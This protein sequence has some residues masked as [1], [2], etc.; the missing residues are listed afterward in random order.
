MSESCGVGGVGGRL[1]G[2]KIGKVICTPCGVCSGVAGAV[3]T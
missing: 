3:G 1:L 2:A